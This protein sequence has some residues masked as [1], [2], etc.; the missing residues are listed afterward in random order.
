M[1]LQFIIGDGQTNHHEA[2]IN[3]ALEWLAV[4]DQEVFFLVPNYNKFEREMELLSSLKAK[5][6][7][8]H[9]S[10]IRS[11]VYSFHRLAWY[12]LQRTGQLGK[13]PITDAG[14]LLLMRK[15]LDRLEDQLV[16][17]RSEVRQTGFI[18]QLLD[19]YQEFQLGNIAAGSSLL[20]MSSEATSHREQNFQLKLKELEVIF[21]AYQEELIQRELQVEQP[22]P[23]LTNY[24]QNL[25][26]TAPETGVR[27][28]K[29]LFVVSGFSN[30]SAQEQALLQ[31]L[32]EKS[33]L[34]VDLFIDTPNET[35]HHFDLFYEG[36]Q[37]YHALKNTAQVAQVP[38]FFDK[39]GEEL[40]NVA[41]GYFQ[42]E[43]LWREHIQGP[44][45]SDESLGAFVE[46]WQGQTP[47]E[48][49]RQIA[50]E[51]KKMV[52]ETKHITQ[53][54]AYRDIQLLTLNPQVYYPLI[55]AIFRE[56]DLP[57]YLDENKKM[58]QHPL[59]ELIQ[60][61]FAL[62]NYHYRLK[63]IFRFLRSELYLP[64][65]WLENEEDW[66]MARNAFRHSVDL[67][68]NVALAHQF[69]GNA[70]VKEKDWM[71]IAY[72]FEANQLEDTQ[73]LTKETN[74]VRQA[75]RQDIVA[76]GLQ[77]KQA[78]TMTEAVTFF[79]EWLIAIGVE[80]Q[81]I[82]WRNQEVARG[83]LEMARNHEQTWDA[84]MEL[85]DQFVA[86]YGDDTF[87]LTLFEEML[88][89]GLANLQFGKIPTAIDQIKINPL[90]LARP[91][92]SKVTFAIGL[93]E[94][95]FPRKV[96]NTTLLSSDERLF[97]NTYLSE[98]Q[99]IRDHSQ[100]I[101][102]NEPFV[103]Y[104][105]FLSASQKLYLTYAKNQDEKQ[106]IQPSPY[107]K[108]LL[109]WGG[110][111]EQERTSLDLASQVSNHVGSYR[112]LVRQLNNLHRQ[113]QDEKQALPKNWR[114]LQEALLQSNQGRL[115]K[116]VL[117]SQEKKNIP[118]RFSSATAKSLYG[119]DIYTSVSRME[120]FYEC[121]YKY[122]ARFGLRL[123][124]REIYGLNPMV[125]G[126]FFHDA[127]DRF[128]RLILQEGQSLVGLT[129]EAK[130]QF[131][132]TILQEIFGMRQYHLLDASPRMQFIRY[133][134]GKTIQRVTWALQ[135][136]SESTRLSPERTEVLFGQVGKEKGIPGLTLALNP[137]SKLYVRGKI[138]RIDVAEVNQQ[139]WLSVIDYKSSNRQFDVTEAYFGLAMQLITYLDVALRDAEQVNA[140]QPV[141]AAG[142]YY[143]HVHNPFVAPDKASEEERLKAF[144]YDG[145]FVDDEEA[146]EIYDYG[147]DAS[148]SS[149]VFPLK[150]NKD[151]VISKTT[152]TDPRFY[153]EQEI[154]WLRK[155]NE[156]K[157]VQGGQRIL[158]G[159]VALNPFYK[160]KDKK[161]ACEYC[162]FRSVCHFD[163]MLKENQYHRIENLKK[164]DI[165]DRIGGEM[166]E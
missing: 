94:A 37:T 149:L 153:T 97:L 150:K 93:D 20:P 51:I 83:H 114:I 59:V 141:K 134:L 144:K 76:F 91:L 104:S 35:D 82:H 122:F 151:S 5:N 15:V 140:N 57:Y 77:L 74:Q 120:T 63:D 39:K 56:L 19:L 156:K 88:T 147:M 139:R 143:F 43:K 6:L 128:L 100:A 45:S 28:E 49:L 130:Q 133:Q 87:E 12:F 112:G 44:S 36:K 29:T 132:D 146:F 11:Q 3:Q 8:N 18:R 107:L 163:V 106:N 73:Q 26:P 137:E 38:V 110:V 46:I 13:E 78:Q 136:Q 22:L 75:F 47:E 69:Q 30:F 90:D 95:N 154:E 166:N 1:S 16:L 9:F 155:H 85:L 157:L 40:T 42:I 2:I 17:Y 32:M 105:V 145:L 135:K 61:F 123:K 121:E 80:E 41:P 159:E 68:E 103:A 162:P 115:A 138:D 113:A 84:L 50:V 129:Q 48:E 55:P 111:K 102:Q 64:K 4:P 24:L 131:V 54:L 158:S 152:K 31:V 108:R 58:D 67:T 66:E 25:D 27:L 101:I 161:R 53:P 165:M 7:S 79:Y 33:H 109:Q 34:C 71:L 125:T 14:A 81:L 148:S 23:L 99:F 89:S 10:T 124:E 62:V 21:A 98:G 92:Q 52:Q 86:I 117:A 118:Q 127:L 119:Q 65:D 60:G 70:W 160:V 126:E 72:D 116:K 142:A 164:T 96:E